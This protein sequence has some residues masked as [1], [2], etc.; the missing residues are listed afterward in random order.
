VKSLRL[1][2]KIDQRCASASSISSAPRGLS[3]SSASGPRNALSFGS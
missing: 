2:D 3:A 1:A